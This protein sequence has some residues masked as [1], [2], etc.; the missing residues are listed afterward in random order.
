MVENMVDQ[1]YGPSLALLATEEV[2]G[3]KYDAH[4]ALYWNV[5]GLFGL[6][7]F[8]FYARNLYESCGEPLDVFH[9]FE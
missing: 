1:D 8:A 2:H 7:P 4:E 9:S 6:K 5:S 3:V